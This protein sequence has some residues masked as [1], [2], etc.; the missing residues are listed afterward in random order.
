MKQ[1]KY[2]T[3][4]GGSVAKTDLCRDILRLFRKW[5]KEPLTAPKIA[6]ILK[7]MGQLGTGKERR[8]YDNLEY[9]CNAG[10]LKKI[11][12]ISDGKRGRPTCEYRFNEDKLYEY[13]ELIE[14]LLIAMDFD[15]ITE[16]PHYIKNGKYPNQPLVKKTVHLTAKDGEFIPLNYI[17]LMGST[18]GITAL[19][20]PAEPEDFEKQWRLAYFITRLMDHCS[21]NSSPAFREYCLK[22][23]RELEPLDGELTVFGDSEQA[24][25]ASRPRIMSPM[26]A[27]F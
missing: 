3:L 10:F 12:A 9:L 24:D 22:R 1:T 21:T 6:D 5:H 7:E 20:R 13:F 23:D 16:D 8:L 2:D 4:V 17:P 26:P 27:Q 25:T 14:D 18:T 19:V 15:P 11:E